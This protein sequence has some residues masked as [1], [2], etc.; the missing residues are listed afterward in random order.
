LA[1]EEQVAGGAELLAW[2]VLDPVALSPLEAQAIPYAVLGSMNDTAAIAPANI[3][4]IPKTA[5]CFAF[6]CKNLIGKDLL[7][8]LHIFFR[9]Y[10]T[11]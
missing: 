3:A 8:G 4:T 5:N 6:I 11:E 1:F 10:V 9:Y 2:A 7:I